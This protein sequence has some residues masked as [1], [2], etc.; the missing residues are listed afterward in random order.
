MALGPTRKWV[1]AMYIMYWAAMAHPKAAL[2]SAEGVDLRDVPPLMGA[3]SSWALGVAFGDAGCV[4]EALATFNSGYDIV[5][6]SGQGDH[7]RYLI[8]DRHIGALLQCGLV[9]DAQ[10][11][12]AELQGQATDLPGGAHLLSAA[13]AGRAA[14]GAGRPAEAHA[15]LEPVIEAFF[16]AGDVNGLGYRFQ[17]SDTIALAMLGESDSAAASLDHLERNFYPSYGFVDYERQLARAWVNASQGLVGPAVGMCL[18]AAKAAE[19]RGQLAAEVVCLQAATQF[20]DRSC[21]ERLRTLASLVE[22]PRADL[23]ARLSTALRGGDAG[24]LALVSEEFE[25]MGD[26][27][28][29]VDAAAHAALAYRHL[30]RRGSALTCSSR[31]EG[32][33]AAHRIA[34]PALRQAADRLPLTDREREIVMLL[35][36]KLSSPA[37]ADRLTLSPRTVENHIYRAMA[38]TGVANREQ[39]AALIWGTPRRVD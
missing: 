1:D 27:V 5:K 16:S 14:L 10:S 33:A 26:L 11:L 35:G 12:A 37:I 22:G 25:R 2:S 19:G 31:A 34:T 36:R 32:L 24:E 15:L 28:A 13:I 20:G 38:K 29:A 6:Q 8:G 30:E 17:L 39:L 4:G 7:L 3:A 21:G 18:S 9:S 23:A